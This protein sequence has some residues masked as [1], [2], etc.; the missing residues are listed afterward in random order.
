MKSISSFLSKFK[1][2]QHPD[3]KKEIVAK[4]IFLETGINLNKTQIDLRGKNIFIKADGYIKTEIYFKKEVI[5]K[6]IAESSLGLKIE[7]IN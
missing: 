2:L 1:S 3:E 7:S 5:L 6:K 4:I